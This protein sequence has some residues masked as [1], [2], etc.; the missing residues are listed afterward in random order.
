MLS[1]SAL[2][3]W[4]FANDPVTKAE[5]FAKQLGCPIKF[6][7]TE[8]IE[9]LQSKS[10]WSDFVEIDMKMFGNDFS[11][12]WGPVLDGVVL[13]S[14]PNSGS[15]LQRM[16]SGEYF[17]YEVLDLIITHMLYLT[18]S[19]FSLESTKEKESF[20]SRNLLRITIT[21]SPA[22]ILIRPGQNY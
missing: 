1:G 12:I 21:T 9:C 3:N 4:A 22:I 6:N 5:F 14:D 20:S 10:T 19:R 17:D 11:P 7:V 8:T 2:A 13:S 15:P 18:S 16:Q